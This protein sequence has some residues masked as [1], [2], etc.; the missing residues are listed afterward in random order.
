MPS[1]RRGPSDVRLTKL[2]LTLYSR[3]VQLRHYPLVHTR[4]LALDFHVRSNFTT[5]INNIKNNV[6]ETMVGFVP[7]VTSANS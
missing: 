5:L 2:G 6:T 1:I 7:Q 4:A 3:I